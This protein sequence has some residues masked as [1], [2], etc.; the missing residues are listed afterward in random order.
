MPKATQVS[1]KTVN[2]VALPLKVKPREKPPERPEAGD[3]A[4][5]IPERLA[6][7]EKLNLKTVKV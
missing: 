1:N 6:R 2:R 5:M 3:P 4:D 7:R